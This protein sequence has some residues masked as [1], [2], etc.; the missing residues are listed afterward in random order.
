MMRV[1]KFLSLGVCI[2]V[3]ASC[4]SPGGGTLAS[5]VTSYTGTMNGDRNGL[6]TAR[7]NEEGEL[8]LTFSFNSVEQNRA[9]VVDDADGTI[10]GD[11]ELEGNQATT[12]IS[13]TFDFDECEATGTWT[14]ADNTSTFNLRSF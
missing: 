4:S 14:E 1:G 9:A 6:V 11:S 8:A 12:A 5:C 3:L 7:L 13:G 10:S 2:K